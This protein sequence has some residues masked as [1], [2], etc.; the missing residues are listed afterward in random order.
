MSKRR[1]YKRG[2]VALVLILCCGAFAW[3]WWIKTSEDS[4][5]PIKEPYIYPITTDM[6]EWERYTFDEKLAMLEM[7]DGL[8]EQMTADALIDT[9]LTY[10]YAAILAAYSEPITHP[11]APHRKGVESVMDN[12]KAL[13]E[14]LER[15]NALHAIEKRI[16][17]YQREDTEN[18]RTVVEAYYLTIIAQYIKAYRQE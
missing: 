11:E 12:N 13:A 18:D 9:V 6:A 2:I 3:C 5:Y 4:R 7:P 16:K 14:L 10:P 8:A 17:E 1:L 15:P